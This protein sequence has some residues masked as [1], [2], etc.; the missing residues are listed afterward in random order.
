MAKYKLSGDGILDTER[1]AHIPMDEANRDYIDYLAWVDDGNT[2]DAEFTAQ[3]IT[4][5]AWS[6]LRGQR[7][8]LLSAT[9]FM[10][11]VD[12]HGA[13]S[14]QEQTDVAAYRNA[15][16]DLPD[17]TVDPENLTWPTKPQ[18]VTDHIG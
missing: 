1:M 14:T 16:R 18:I 3:E 2:A 15:L 12:F 5:N 4:D 13:M 7:D 9:D 6:A 10:M 8:M 11:T 17:N